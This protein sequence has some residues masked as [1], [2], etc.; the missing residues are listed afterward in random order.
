LR[1][2]RDLHL[3]RRSH[4]EDKPQIQE[5]FTLPNKQRFEVSLTL[6]IRQVPQI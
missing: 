4:F 1:I 6:A 5:A 2:Q 3:W